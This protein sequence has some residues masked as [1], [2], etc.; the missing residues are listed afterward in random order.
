MR[1]GFFTDSYPPVT[2]GISYS[3]LTFRKHL[4][5]MGHEVFVLAPA[6]GFRY[7]ERDPHIIRV[8]AF[9][10]LFYDSYLT[11]VF[12]PPVILAKIKRLKLD[13]VHYHTPGQVGLM[14]VYYALQNRKP[15]ISTYHTDLYQ[16]VLHYPQVLPGSL[17]L[18]LIAPMITR[19]GIQDV[20]K[21]FESARPARSVDAWNQKVVMK[22][23]TLLHNHCDRVIA[24][25][26]KIDAQ[27]L[28][29]GTKTPIRILPTG[30]DRI[31]ATPDEI[32]TFR[33]RFHLRLSDQM[34]LYVGR[35]GSEKNLDML[36]EAFS[37]LAPNHPNLKLMM[38]GDYGY[39]VKLEEHSRQLGL[40]DRIIFTGY[41]AHERLGAAYAVADVLAFPSRTDTQGLVVHEAAC[42]GLP[43]I[44]TDPDVTEVV[45]EG[46]NGFF[47][48]NSPRDFAKKLDVLLKDPTLRAGMGAAS[49]KIAATYSGRHQTEKLIRMY[50]TVLQARTRAAVRPRE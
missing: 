12:F 20:R 22:M 48:K 44:M 41:L 31:P 23:I 14:G 26:R 5:D 28:S 33:R 46:V 10:G 37:H 35:L 49:Q 40:E 4:E 18:T 30:V 47:A 7:K 39:R 34:I 50:E 1:I 8:P 38:I 3:T 32:A 42:A 6:P 27:L 24:P 45:R 2:D 15:L 16:Y 21:A 29:W 9:K 13:I 19:G 43:I 11:S 25:S 17:A 36:I